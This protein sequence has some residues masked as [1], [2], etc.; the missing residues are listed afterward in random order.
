MAERQRGRVREVQFQNSTDSS[1]K[2]NS[3]FCATVQSNCCQNGYI[4]SLYINYVSVEFV[5]KKGSHLYTAWICVQSVLS[6][7]P[8]MI[9]Y[10]NSKQ[11]FGKSLLIFWWHLCFIR[12]IQNKVNKHFGSPTEYQTQFQWSPFGNKWNYM[13]SVRLSTIAS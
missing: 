2:T 5:P 1:I 11:T 3:L 13:Y 12:W 7:A 6:G 8:K 4:K 10:L 9:V